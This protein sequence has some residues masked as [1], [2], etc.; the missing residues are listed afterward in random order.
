MIDIFSLGQQLPFLPL[1]MVQLQLSEVQKKF[2]NKPVFEPVSFSF[3]GSVLG[4][5]GANGSGKTTLMRCLAFLLSPT[6]GS[7]LWT[8]DEKKI[9]PANFRALMAYAAPYISLYP[10]LSVEEN[11][12][13]SAE[14]GRNSA[15]SGNVSEAL[16]IMGATALLSKPFGTLSSGQKQRIKIA[17]ALIRKPKI[18]F[19]DEPGTNLDESG[20][21]CVAECVRSASNSG[22]FVIIASNE[23][24]ELDV[25][26]QVIPLKPIQTF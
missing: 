2:N 8:I 20:K 3:S 16:E 18:L 11:L 13:L 26:E 23:K 1:G 17:G 21:N 14:L 25:C 7:L 22:V 9:E 24:N 15:Y 4:I 19:L 12:R 6:Q 5:S 10:E